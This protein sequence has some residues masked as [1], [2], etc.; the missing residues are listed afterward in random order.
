MRYLII[1]SRFVFHHTVVCVSFLSSPS[2]AYFFT[3]SLPCKLPPEILALILGLVFDSF[4]S[5]MARS[6]ALRVLSSVSG[7]WRL[8]I[9]SRPEWWAA[10]SIHM[11][12]LQFIT[13]L[14]LSVNKPIAFSAF[15]EGSLLYFPAAFAAISRRLR[16]LKSGYT[17]SPQQLMRMFFE[18]SR[19]R[20]VPFHLPLLEDG[21]FRCRVGKRLQ[22]N[23]PIHAPVL[24][25][26][27]IRNVL[28]TFFAPALRS[29]MLDF[30]DRLS[31][32]LLAFR[33]TLLSLSQLDDL[34]FSIGNIILDSRVLPE[35]TIPHVRSLI[36]SATCSPTKVCR[37][38]AWTIWPEL[39]LLSVSLP[40]KNP[41]NFF[42][43]FSPTSSPLLLIVQHNL[44]RSPPHQSSVAEASSLAPLRR[45]SQAST[46][47][48]SNPVFPSTDIPVPIAS[49][50]L[51]LILLDPSH[52]SHSLL[53]IATLVRDLNSFPLRCLSLY[54]VCSTCTDC[55]DAA[56]R[57]PSLASASPILP[58]HLSFLSQ[59][60]STWWESILSLLR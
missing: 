57:P 53:T 16:L 27:Y 36:V 52:S 21:R 8:Y 22:Y 19:E 17:V 45:C 6:E 28:P 35:M 1:S 44:P 30:H 51:R 2:F 60:A 15:L 23:L 59:P 56:F 26:F 58:D 31:F 46:V 40:L 29:L 32:S 54:I 43:I 3:G 47:I 12:P 7:A 24:S 20:K 37:L 9:R 39:R 18:H 49:S 41:S 4:P 50:L 13:H 25:T 34:H 38:L 10:L 14:H 5:H 33:S 48:I 42:R 55:M 11:T